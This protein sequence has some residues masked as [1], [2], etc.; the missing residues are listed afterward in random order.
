MME[1]SPSGDSKPGLLSKKSICELVA[2]LKPGGWRDLYNLVSKLPHS[3]NNQGYYFDLDRLPDETI[4]Q[5]SAYLIESSSVF[6]DFVRCEKER[7]AMVYKI[8]K[9]ME[10]LQKRGRGG[11][12][13]VRAK[14]STIDLEGDPC[15]NDDEV[16]DIHMGLSEY[17]GLMENTDVYDDEVFHEKD[18]DD[19][20]DD[21]GQDTESAQPPNVAPTT[22]DLDDLV[23]K[24]HKTR[25]DS[26]KYM[27]SSYFTAG[28]WRG[29]EYREID[30]LLRNEAKA[31]LAGGP[32]RRSVFKK[33]PSASDAAK[34]GRVQRLPDV[35]EREKY[36]E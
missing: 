31:I 15:E 33:T 25:S 19:D 11:A 9:N 23:A 1:G 7:V 14:H 26:R 3:A 21:D 2:R 20:D 30:E 6:E 22:C 32:L 13:K 12:A 10:S 8:T 18:L 5:I 4:Q 27:G 16:Y 36:S 34:R 24:Y 29:N 35:L 28:R 17:D